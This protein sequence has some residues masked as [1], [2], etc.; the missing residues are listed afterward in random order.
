M[1]KGIPSHLFS[2]VPI[3]LWR[4]DLETIMFP[5]IIPEEL[6]GMA[7]TVFYGCA[8]GV[9]PGRVLIERQSA[10]SVIVHSKSRNLLYSRAKFNYR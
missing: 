8:K 7:D 5:L 3:L 10:S 6:H 1:Q 2:L 4:D 9:I